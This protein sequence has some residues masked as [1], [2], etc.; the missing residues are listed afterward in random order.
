MERIGSPQG[1]FNRLLPADYPTICK[2]IRTTPGVSMPCKVFILLAELVDKWSFGASW[3][4]LGVWFPRRSFL[5]ST[6]STSFVVD[7]PTLEFQQPEI[8]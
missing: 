8:F 5:Y 3:Q 7:V 4:T 6:I 2:T 1:T